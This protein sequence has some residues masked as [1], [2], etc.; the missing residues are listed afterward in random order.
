MPKKKVKKN[1]KNWVIAITTMLIIVVVGVFMLYRW[2]YSNNIQKNYHE[3]YFYIQSNSSYADVIEKLTEEGIIINERSFNWVAEQK[4]YPNNVKPGR[5][6][7]QYPLS[8]N[9][10][11]NLLRSGEQTPLQV[12]VKSFRKKEHLAAYLGKVLEPD[13]MQFATLFNNEQILKEYG[14]LPST[15]PAII[16]PNTYEFYWNT[17]PEQFISKMA[18]EYKKFWTDERKQKAKNIGLTQSEVS[19]LAS[20][21]QSET[22]KNDEKPKVAGV[23]LNRLKKGMKLQADPTLIFAWNDFSIKRV[24]NIH[25][26]ITSP[27]N[28][29]KYE[30]LPPGPILIPELSSI[31]AVLNAETHNFLYFCAKEDFSGYHNFASTYTQHLRN[32]RL[33]QQALNKRKIFK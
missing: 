3:P 9:I 27:Y 7:I 21:V 28:T 12:I 10:L 19:I 11:V 23:Y 26:E 13:S 20:I 14:F 25:K 18:L 16:L 17:S 2:V 15:F 8:N 33:Y 6:I 22:A 32:A 30:G 24:L 4:N 5:Y 1:N 29:Y 31:D